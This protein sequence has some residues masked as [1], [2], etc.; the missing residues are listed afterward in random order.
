M[1]LRFSNIFFTVILGILTPHN[2]YDSNCNR[3]TT[4]KLLSHNSI[5]HCY[6][7]NR[8]VI[9][10]KNS[11][12]ITVFEKYEY[13]LHRNKKNYSRRNYKLRRHFTTSVGALLRAGC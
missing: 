8:N 2:H 5:L 1:Y 12:F 4:I 3:V 6:G 13:E 7:A 9:T 10:I 11:S